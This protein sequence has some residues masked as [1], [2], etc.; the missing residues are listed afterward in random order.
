MYVEDKFIISNIVIDNKRIN[1]IIE[2]TTYIYQILL[3]N[4][5]YDNTEDFQQFKLIV[6]KHITNYFSN[7][8]VNYNY[9]D[10]LLDDVLN[11]FIVEENTIFTLYYLY[12]FLGID[13]DQYIKENIFNNCIL[14]FIFYNNLEDIIYTINEE[15]IYKLDKIINSLNVI[16]YN[17]DVEELFNNMDLK[18]YILALLNNK[19][20]ENK[21]LL[22]DKCNNNYLK[23]IG[24]Y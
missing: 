13:I 9:F 2:D 3:N 21:L 15:E 19:H 24:A 23:K 4:C 8:Y 22:I 20:Y 11:Y 1:E 18:R 10:E 17:I 14:E 6:N 16:Y 5:N 12:H 7:Y